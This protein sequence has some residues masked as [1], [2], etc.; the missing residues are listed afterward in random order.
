MEGEFEVDQI[1]DSDSQ[2]EGS[3]QKSGDS[4]DAFC[5]VCYSRAKDTICLPCRHLCICTPCSDIIKH[6]DA[7]SNMRNRCPLCRCM[8]SSFIHISESTETSN[9]EQISEASV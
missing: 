6:M 4:T 9:T 3:N 8:A 2:A 5:V 7:E 1:Y